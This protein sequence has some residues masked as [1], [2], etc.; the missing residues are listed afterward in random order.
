[1]IVVKVHCCVRAKSGGAATAGIKGKH[2]KL[3][4]EDHC[5]FCLLVQHLDAEGIQASSAYNVV[6]EV[7]LHSLALARE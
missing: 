4:H 3:A 1:M 2:R 6:A 7:W 5:L